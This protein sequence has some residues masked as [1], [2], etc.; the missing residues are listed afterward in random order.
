MA[1]DTAQFL[2]TVNA[3]LVTVSGLLIVAGVGAARR[4]RDDL[5]ARRM[6][7]ATGLLTVFLL[8]YLGR[9]AAFGITPFRG[10]DWARPIYYILLV[11][12]VMVATLSTPLI[13]WNLLLARRRELGRHRRLGRSVYPL[14]LYVAAT[15]P[16]VYLALYHL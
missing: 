15:G 2:A 5:H 11:T 6:S 16:L 3:L 4:G 9:F 14:W 8:L 7:L 12:H 1:P 10:P 13:L